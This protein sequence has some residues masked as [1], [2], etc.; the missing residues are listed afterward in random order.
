MVLKHHCVGPAEIKTLSDATE[1]DI[2]PF[3]YR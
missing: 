2:N 1:V 3:I